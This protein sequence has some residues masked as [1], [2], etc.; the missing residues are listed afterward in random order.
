M[1][2]PDLPAMVLG[3]PLVAGPLGLA[4][5]AAIYACWRSGAGWTCLAVVI[6]LAWLAQAG[7]RR[8]AWEAWK[9]EWDAMAEPAPKRPRGTKRAWAAALA[10]PLGLLLYLSA[11]PAARPAIVGVG[12]LLGLAVLLVATL[13]W[14]WR[15]LRARPRRRGV[16]PVAVIAKPLIAVPTLD[17]AYAALPEHCRRILSGSRP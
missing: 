14:A 9:R 2:R 4:G 6:G 10:V 1:R 7:E 13:R 3:H 11:E 16:A 8:A 15:R 17:A 12:L 5:F